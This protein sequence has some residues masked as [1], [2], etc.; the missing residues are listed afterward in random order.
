MSNIDL[1]TT[2]ELGLTDIKKYLRYAGQVKIELD[3]LYD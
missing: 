3:W 2:K 1:D